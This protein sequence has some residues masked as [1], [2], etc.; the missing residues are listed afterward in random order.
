MWLVVGGCALAAALVGWS[1]GRLAS[2]SAGVSSAGERVAKVRGLL[3]AGSLLNLVLSGLLAAGVAHLFD[4]PLAA[5]TRV[6]IGGLCFLVAVGMAEWHLANRMFGAYRRVRPNR[7]SKRAFRFRLMATTMA[8]AFPL[9][10]SVILIGSLVNL[11]NSES[12]VMDVFAKGSVLVL[13]LFLWLFQWSVIRLVLLP[14]RPAE[15]PMQD[16]EDDAK[17]LCERMGT[18][19]NDLMM[20]RTGRSRIAGAFALGGGK[21]ALTDDLVAALTHEEFLAIV[22]HEARH[23]L[24][25]RRT[26]LAIVFLTTVAASVGAFA[27]WGFSAGHFSSW[28]AMLLSVCGALAIMYPIAVLKRRNED[29]ADDAAIAAVGAMPLMTALVKTYAINGRMEDP[30]SSSIHRGLQDRLQRIAKVSGCG[31]ESLDRA[32]AVATD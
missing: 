11:V 2:R 27:A 14:G 9:G 22:A 29:E 3:R 17:E 19:L 12:G 28:I 21:I 26:I 13:A 32:L 30:S 1:F 8:V 15:F 7:M 6:M 10:V 20:L 5:G 18:R 4:Q 16:W 25:R 24:Q 23:F 31:S